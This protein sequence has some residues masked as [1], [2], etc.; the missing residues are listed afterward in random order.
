MTNHTK[1]NIELLKVTRANILETTKDLSF[2][3]LT[4]IPDGFSN[5]IIWNIIHLTV[6]EQLLCY[7]LSGNEIAL[8]KEIIAKF[9][10]GSS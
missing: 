3:E 6:T 7:G 8:N 1:Q 10:K 9:R 5:S 4:T 2:Q